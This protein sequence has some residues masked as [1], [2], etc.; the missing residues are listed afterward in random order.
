MGR[1][2]FEKTAVDLVVCGRFSQ[3]GEGELTPDS[4]TESLLAEL[5]NELRRNELS[6]YVSVKCCN[7]GNAREQGVSV[8]VLP[9]KV[10][11][12]EIH[13]DT[14]EKIIDRHVPVPVGRQEVSD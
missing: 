12:L 10:R 7:C 5:T 9:E 2:S 4:E 6:P 1:S 3:N 13:P 14:I 11:Y 8:T